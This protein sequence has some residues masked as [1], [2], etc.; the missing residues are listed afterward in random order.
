MPGMSMPGMSME[1][2]R[3]NL[4]L[5]GRVPHPVV[6]VGNFDG[7]HLGHQ[8][9]LRA[10]VERA[11]AR[12]G[13]SVALTFEPHPLTVLQPGRDFRLLTPFEEKA[14]RLDELGIQVLAVATFT[15]QFA[16]LSPRDF[17]KQVLY[18][19]L[20][21]EVVLVGRDFGFGHGRTGTP[22][23]LK[24]LGRDLGFDVEVTADVVMDGSAVRSSR[25]R[26]LLAQGEV[27]ATRRLLGR[28]YAIRGRVIR[29]AGRGKRLGVPT[30][31]LD[32]LSELI[33]KEGVYAVSAT[34]TPLTLP[35]SLEGRGAQER[36]G[37]TFGGAGY[38]G[39][40]PTFRGGDRGG[41][42]PTLQ[43][44][45]H[46]F[47]YDGGDLYGKRLRLAFIARLRDDMT[48]DDSTGLVRQMAEDLARARRLMARA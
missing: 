15:P 42:Q 10:A 22:E 2:L 27:E 44:E 41:G 45:A 16:A 32:T 14:E 20:G 40:Q 4:N 29:G 43:I 7:L 28:P 39:R 11:R 3:G 34:L 17:A 46:L 33:P 9:I 47:D 31:N 12:Q 26:S 25:V 38:I 36:V 13:T 37:P 5:K 21:A 8:A 6:A 35:L 30:A 1:V 19:Q 48:F 23:G 24:A 18:D